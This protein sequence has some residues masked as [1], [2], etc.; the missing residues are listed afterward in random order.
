MTWHLWIL[1]TLFFISA[2]GSRYRSIFR[3]CINYVKRKKLNFTVGETRKSWFWCLVKTETEIGKSYSNRNSWRR[4]SINNYWRK[5]LSIMN[6]IF[7]SCP[8]M[9]TDKQGEKVDPPFFMRCWLTDVFLTRQHR[10]LWLV[11]LALG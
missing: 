3:N 8:H 10:V 6:L 1:A 5:F 2:S 11:D 4:V 7:R 9:H